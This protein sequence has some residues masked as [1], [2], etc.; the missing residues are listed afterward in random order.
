VLNRVGFRTLS[1]AGAALMV[2]GY[3]ALALRPDVD[4]A[5][6]LA[7]GGTIGVG[8]GLISIT[9]VVALQS[10]I[11]PARRGVA[12]SG[13]LFFRNVGATLGVALMGATLNAR[14][15][16]RLAGLEIGARHL[17]A[18]LVPELIRGIG[19]VFWL[20]AGATVLA[21][22]AT[23]FLPSRTP[24]SAAAAASGELLG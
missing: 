16:V 24:R 20:G 2:L 18:D 23:C 4:W 21:L 17:P 19:V 14:L 11:E 15:G 12:T 8:M 1:I 3:T 10:A 9:T 5:S 7:I 22:L 13:L 6:L